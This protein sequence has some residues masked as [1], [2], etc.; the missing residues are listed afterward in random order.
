M[1][2]RTSRSGCSI[3]CAECME[4]R[5]DGEAPRGASDSPAPAPLSA[6]AGN[7]ARSAPMPVKTLRRRSSA[8]AQ[9]RAR[10]LRLDSA[11]GGGGP[12]PSR[13]TSCFRRG[14]VGAPAP[15]RAP[16][17]EPAAKRRRPAADTRRPHPIIARLEPK[18]PHPVARSARQL[19]AP[20]GEPCTEPSTRLLGLGRRAALGEAGWR[21]RR[22]CGARSALGG[23]T[24]RA[25][26]TRASAASRALPAQLRLTAAWKVRARDL[27]RERWGLPFVPLGAPIASL[28][29]GS[30]ALALQCTRSRGTRSS[31]RAN[32][33][34][35]AGLRG[36]GRGR[37]DP[38]RHRR[39][40]A[41]RLVQPG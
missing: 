6:R 18:N 39:S 1:P 35:E 20:V 16:H 29:A 3:R 22:R 8:C 21:R 37:S 2:A 24:P 25:A 28:A 34:R 4:P 40:R 14:L 13:P 9:R 17:P 38:H 11:P 32:G 31:K 26:C 23:A 19:R 33:P 10:R 30:A 7:R 5:L 15:K 12:K 41:H 36:K 27:R